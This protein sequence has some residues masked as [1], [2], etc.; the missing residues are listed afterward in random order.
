MHSSRRVPVAADCPPRLSPRPARTRDPRM[1]GGRAVRTRSA[2]SPVPLL[3][4]GPRRAGP[5]RAGAAF[6]S[7][8]GCPRLALPQPR[9]DRERPR[10]VGRGRD[11]YEGPG[12]QPSRHESRAVQTGRPQSEQRA[13]ALTAYASATPFTSAGMEADGADS[14]APQLL[15]PRAASATM[16]AARSRSLTRRRAGV[17]ED[18]EAMVFGDLRAAAEAFE[19]MPLLSIVTEGPELRTVAYKG[20]KTKRV[21]RTIELREHSGRRVTQQAVEGTRRVVTRAGDRGGRAGCPSRRR[22]AARAGRWPRRPARWAGPDRRSSRWPCSR[23][24]PR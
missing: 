24:R 18:R 23:G 21:V 3:D 9:R 8:V 22:R 1:A 5:C 4:R 7:G 15:D 12:K 13:L 2:P 11:G 19:H 16:A 10:R 20:G 17:H 6:P 14:S